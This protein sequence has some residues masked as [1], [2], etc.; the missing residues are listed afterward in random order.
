MGRQKSNQTLQFTIDFTANVGK[1]TKQLDAEVSNLKTVVGKNNPLNAW[2]D[3]VK[4]RSADLRNAFSDM[5]QS[6]TKPGLSRTQFLKNLSNAQ[7]IIRSIN[8]NLARSQ[9][10]L[11]RSFNSKG[12]QANLTKLQQLEKQYEKLLA[13]KTAYESA[14]GTLKSKKAGYKQSLG[15]T[16]A[17]IGKK[18]T[19]AEGINQKK[20][21][22]LTRKELNF[23]SEY[24]DMIPQIIDANKDLIASQEAVNKVFEKLGMS[25]VV[26]SGDLTNKIASTKTDIKGQQDIT[27]T[28]D[29]YAEVSEA[30]KIIEKGSNDV[31]DANKEMGEA[32]EKSSAQAV[33]AMLDEEQA[34]NSVKSVLNEFGISLSAAGLANY[35]KQLVSQSWEFYKSLDA[36][37]TEISIVSNYGREQVQ[38]LTNDFISLSQKTGMAIDDIAQASV[39]F[40]QQGLNTDEVMTMTEVTAQFAKVAGED[41]TTAAD[42]LTAAVN[43]FQIGVEHAIDVADKLNAVAAKSAASIEEIS[44]AMEKSAAQA[45][46]AGVSM[47]RYLAYIA[48]MEEVTREAPE[49]IGT[50]LKT[51][52]AR[53]Q[54]VKMSGTSEDGE[55]D[56]NQV[57]TALKSVGIALRDSQNQLRDL[58]DVL[59]ELGPKWNSLDRNTQAYLGTVIA[60]TRQQ[61]RFIAL[62]QNWDRA[63]ELTAVSENSA[64]QQALMHAKAMEGLD[65]SINTLTNSWQKFLTTLTSSDAFINIL[66]TLS[67]VLQNI[68]QRGGTFTLA[69]GALGMAIATNSKKVMAFSKVVG[70]LGKN[71]VD[72]AKQVKKGEKPWKSFGKEIQNS[73]K[74][75]NKN[76]AVMADLKKGMDAISEIRGIDAQ[77]SSLEMQGTKT[78]AVK[79]KI[80]ELRRQK[81]LL[82]QTNNLEKLSSDELINKYNEMD[83]EYQN[84]QTSTD[85]AAMSMANTASAGLAVVSGLQMLI[86]ALGLA[87]NS[88]VQLGIAA[89]A[90]GV[91]IYALI[92][93][94]KAGEMSWH[95]FWSAATLGLGPIIS[96]LITGLISLVNAFSGMGSD[97]SEELAELKNKQDEYTDSIKATKAALNAVD[98]NLKVYDSLSK[99][100]VKTTE[101]QEQL[102]QAIK[103]MAEYYELDYFD[104]GDGTYSINIDDVKA[105]RDIEAAELDKEIGEAQENLHKTMNQA[106]DTKHKQKHGGWATFWEWGENDDVEINKEV[107]DEYQATMLSYLDDISDDMN[108]T[109]DAYGNVI[110]SAG[111]KQAMQS[112]ILNNYYDT[113]QK[114][115]EDKTL[116]EEELQEAIIAGQE[117]FNKLFT[118]NQGLYEEMIQMNNEFADKASTR[119][120]GETMDRIDAYYEKLKDKMLEGLTEGTEEYETALDQWQALVDAAYENALG[121][122]GSNLYDVMQYYQGAGSNLYG[123]LKGLN[124]NTLNALNTSGAL[125]DTGNT[126]DRLLEQLENDLPTITQAYNASGEAGALALIESFDRILNDTGLDDATRF[127]AQEA[128]EA[129]IE[130]LTVSST[131]TWVQLA[132]T[133]DEITSSLSSMNKLVDTLRENGGWTLDEFKELGSV[134]DDIR[135]NWDLLDS[136]TQEEYLAAVQK[137]NFAYDE[138]NNL[139]SADMN[140]TQALA[141]IKE[142]YAKAQIKNTINQLAA[143]RSEMQVKLAAYNAEISAT[144]ELIGSLKAKTETGVTASDL[145]TMAINS[146]ANNAIDADTALADVYSSMGTNAQNMAAASIEGLEVVGSLLNAIATGDYA[147]AETLANTFKSKVNA[148][149]ANYINRIKSS[150]VAGSY[151]NEDGGVDADKMD[152]FIADLEKYKS[153]LVEA[154]KDLAAEI[155]NITEQI[156]WWE[157]LSESDLSGWGTEAAKA[158]EEYISKL[159]KMLDLI[160]HIERETFKLSMY[161]K[162]YEEQTGKTN[163]KNLETQITLV[164]HLQGDYKKAY[165]LQKTSLNELTTL[166]RKGYGDIVSFDQEG[167]YTVDYEKLEKLHDKN[168]EELEDLLGQYDESIAKVDEY[169]E[170]LLDKMVE[171]KTL[172]QEIVDKYIEAEDQLVEAIKQREEKILDN[173]LAAIDKEIEAIEKA[174]EARRKAREEEQDAEELSSMQVDLQRALMDSSG[175]SASQI[176]EIQKQIKDKQQEMADNSF[177]TMVEDMQLQLEEEQELEQ[178][179]FDE[180]LEEMDWYWDEVDRIMAEGTETVLDTMQL[181]LDDFNQASE[182]QQV[183]LLKGWT[184][185]FEQAAVIGKAGALDMQSVIADIQNELNTQ[186]IEQYLQYLDEE[187]VNTAYTGRTSY[188]DPAPKS[189][190]GKGSGG[191]SGNTSNKKYSGSGGS[192]GSVTDKVISDIDNKMNTKVEPGTLVDDSVKVPSY[193]GEFKKLAVGT[194]LEFKPGNGKKIQG[195]YTSARSWDSAQTFGSFTDPEGSDINAV[196]QGDLHYDGSWQLSNGKKGAYIAKFTINGVNL[197]MPITKDGLGTSSSGNGIWWGKQGWFGTGGSYYYKNGGMADFTGPAWLDGTKAAPEAVLNAMQTKAFLSFTDDL[198]ALRAEGGVSTNSSVVIDSISFNVESMSSVADG[199]KAFDA[200]VDKFKEIGAKQGISILGTSNRN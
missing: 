32:A 24:K 154:R 160:T 144:E 66:N 88:F 71:L 185:V 85:A 168:Q 65:A 136:A 99:K 164:K 124:T 122:G 59:S 110:A 34:I 137:M 150:A 57:E 18:A 82:I 51:I 54:Q 198:A 45:N 119:T 53:F 170:N 16:P 89:V 55:T 121:T 46:Q 48:T 191:G 84:L 72:L 151:I 10:Y 1:L 109:Y 76:K 180:R 98:S 44:T 135:A 181:Y 147:K 183:E 187:T 68:S 80:E 14:S 60:G 165:E 190:G 2:F 50:S 118:E 167:N 41:V 112:K 9:E 117:S 157:R 175:A 31:R 35:F 11:N 134:M 153:G 37:L 70:K 148:L 130:E 114:S 25:D 174:A 103:D 195:I 120:F 94:I 61:S 49:N 15:M 83:L 56:V 133:L 173:K 152:E 155:V 138:Q 100:L 111:E 125:D 7:E 26:D 27:I 74:L 188:T 143:A 87:D 178:K 141:K 108:T 47:D 158:A 97:G 194:D 139:I 142:T 162:L 73:M 36:A 13:A 106:Q 8:T 189:T 196:Y 177:D 79:S 95:A 169:Y 126:T 192:S 52:M 91:A 176:L 184:N 131:K 102:N 101:E 127:A 92:P 129:L 182:L 64:G 28:P 19:M 12:N 4:G 186:D 197:Y 21:K 105:A 39:I 81:E 171:E 159:R 33:Q 38:G 163:V 3:G 43:G 62:M 5:T 199:E 145:E 20:G 23:L 156:E 90:I 78:E 75:I 113:L 30:L 69:V 104:N 40:F 63:L 166:I 179:M 132:D 22:N 123:V 149:G 128:K 200:F 77:I 93:A 146:Y 115:Y 17:E 172:R 58:D 86:S 107:A 6:L 96:L 67:A 29:Q 42:Q 161:Q 193:S 140:A 116:N